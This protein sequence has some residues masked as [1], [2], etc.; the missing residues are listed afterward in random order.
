MRTARRRGVHGP[1][2]DPLPTNAVSTGTFRCPEAGQ[3][4]L[5]VLR[6][7]GRVATGSGSRRGPPAEPAT[8]G[9]GQPLLYGQRVL[10]ASSRL[11]VMNRLGRALT[12]STRS[13][14]LERLLEGAGYPARLAEELGL[15]RTN[16]S[17]H[18]ACLRGCGIV[19]A[20]PEGRHTR[21]E[22]ADPHLTIAIE[23]LVK[24]VLAVDDGTDC[25]IVGCDV[26]LC[27][28]PGA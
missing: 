9:T 26:P 22:I 7:G 8:L 17:N 2:L 24:V 18:L 4:L 12:D 14:I 1:G 10:T 28:G 19:V 13:R 16:V 27:C 5:W 25:T 15:T 11:E 20:T 21:Y 23:A 3:G 6:G